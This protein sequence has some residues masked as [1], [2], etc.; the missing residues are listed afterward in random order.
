MT[1]TVL[2]RSLAVALCLVPAAIPAAAQAPGSGPRFALVIGN[3]NYVE[4]GKLKNPANDAADMAAA[5]RDLGFKV[6]LLTD[7]D[8][9]KMEDAVI[10]LGTNLSQSADST[11][12]FFY[13]GHGVQSGGT[14]YLIPAD[15]RI[16]SETF[17]KTKALAAQS[18]LDTLQSSRNALNVIVLDA[19][20][21]NPFSWS[22]SGTRGLTV[23]GSQP[24]GSIVAYATSAGSVAQDGTGRNGLFTQELLKNLRVFDLEIKDVFNRTGAAVQTVSS[25][26][27]IPA[28][29]NQ[30]FGSA[31]LAGTGTARPSSGSVPAAKPS[32]GAAVAATGNLS[33][34]LV[35]P[36]R[37]SVGGVSADVPAGTVPVNGLPAGPTTVAV[38]YGDGKAET[39]SLTIEAGKT[40]SVSFSYAPAPK[41]AAIVASAPA[42]R[43]PSLPL[44]G[45]VFV[46]G[47]TFMMGRESTDEVVSTKPVHEVLLSDFWIMATETTQKDYAALMGRNPAYNTV[48]DTYP[49]FAVSWFG[50]LE[51]ANKLSLRDGLRPAYTISGKSAACDWSANGWRLPTEA[52]W[53]YAARGGQASRGYIYS[54]SDDPEAVAWYSKNTGNKGPKPVGTKAPNELGLYDMSGN[55][56][57]Y[58]WDRRAPYAAGRQTDPRGPDSGTGRVVR[59]GSFA[60]IVQSLATADRWSYNDDLPSN[61]AGI[62][63]VRSA[64]R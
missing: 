28:V 47:G 54:G 5:L 52:E 51:Y 46:K 42:A 50:A 24:P 59:G 41:S 39:A 61:M 62:R 43:N 9:S 10:R 20:R 32:F 44:R 21:D 15:A 17:L 57:E 18:V 33:V 26:K 58:C 16:A 7:A 37:V 55:M 45:E 11:G 34:R 12:F 14:N 49:V 27:Q 22:R 38:T 6:D 1:K 2:A 36:G 31:Y 25:G 8:L 30:F 29:Y 63:L 48:G 3:G 53:E 13:A 56:Y 19:C 60:N 64:G 35:A 4:L 40:A 23:V